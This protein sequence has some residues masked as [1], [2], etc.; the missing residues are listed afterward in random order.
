MLHLP[1]KFKTSKS[2]SFYTKEE[3]LNLVEQSPE[4]FSNN[5]VTRPLMEEWLFNT[6]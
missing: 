5:V 1:G 3:L 2:N 6:I 4:R